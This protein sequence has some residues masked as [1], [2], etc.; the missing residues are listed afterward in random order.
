MGLNRLAL[1]CSEVLLLN[2]FVVSHAGVTSSYVRVSEPSEEMPLEKYPP[3]ASLNAPDE[4]I[5]I[6]LLSNQFL[7]FLFLLSL[8]T[9]D[10]SLLILS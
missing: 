6:F 1:V 3:P 9:Y 2:I 10:R 4:V 8:V 5:S 7:H